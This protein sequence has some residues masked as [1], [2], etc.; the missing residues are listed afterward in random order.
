MESAVH[1]NNLGDLR[2]K[3]A[4]E[5]IIQQ[6]DDLFNIM[7]QTSWHQPMLSSSP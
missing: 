7:Q 4:W 6:E 3:N 5:L 2:Q 1:K